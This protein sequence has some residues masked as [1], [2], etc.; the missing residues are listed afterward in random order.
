MLHHRF[1]AKHCHIRGRTAEGAGSP[2]F[3]PRP[4]GPLRPTL[5]GRVGACVVHSIL[6]R[7]VPGSGAHL[8]RAVALGMCC[9]H[10]NNKS[11]KGIAAS[12]VGSAR[13]FDLLY[14]TAQGCS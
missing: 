4:S 5:P 3:S 7:C 12:A 11:L 14:K 2:L 10:P 9:A 1:E 8:D 13:A 6:V